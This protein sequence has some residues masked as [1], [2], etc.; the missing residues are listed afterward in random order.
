MTGG[1]GS[2][3]SD[4]ARH[5]QHQRVGW[6]ELFYDL[7]IVAAVGYAAHTFAEHPTWG[8]GL[9]IAAWTLIM[10]VLWLLTALN[11]NLYPGDHPWRRVLGLVQMLALVVA[12]LGTV[13][14]EGLSNSIGFAGLAVAFGSVA[15]AYALAMRDPAVDLRAVRVLGWSSGAAALVLLLGVFLPDDAEWTLTGAPPWILAVGV[16][17]V[18]IPLF[19]VVVTR[20][21]DRIDR[22]HMGER[23]GQLVII[24]LGE[25]FMSLVSALGGRP[26]IPNPLF[27]V[28]TFLVVFAIWTLYFSSVLPAGLPRSPGRLRAWLLTHWLLMFGAV[29]TAAGF[30]AVTL[31]PFGTEG[32]TGVSEWTALPMTFVMVSLA[33]LTWLGSDSVTPLVRLHLVATGALVVLAVL[34]MAITAGG[35]NWEV[36]IG[37]VVVMADAVLAVRWAQPYRENH[38]TSA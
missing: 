28:L 18:A 1:P 26:S 25:S 20:V 27:F 11:N 10:F 14:D 3:G 22:E 32:T 21:S 29:G 15:A 12:S 33:L 31:V 16:G 30:S 6:F 23:L 37:S 34:G 19:G 35:E 13:A 8:L 24:V 7:V 2:A 9:W 38:V 17:I 5:P 36:A 4:P